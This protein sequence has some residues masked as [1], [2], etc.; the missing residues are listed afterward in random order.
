MRKIADQIFFQID[1]AASA[2]VYDIKDRNVFM[3]EE[4]DL[5]FSEYTVFCCVCVGW[6]SMIDDLV[7]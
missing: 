7:P 6:G 5:L 2:F 1:S 3:S 4:N